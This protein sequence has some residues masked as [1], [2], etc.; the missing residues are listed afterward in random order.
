MYVYS[1]EKHNV[2]MQKNNI[3][4]KILQLSVKFKGMGF[5]NPNRQDVY[6][7]IDEIHKE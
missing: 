5:I 2:M 7:N 3:W 1:A 6:Y 4:G